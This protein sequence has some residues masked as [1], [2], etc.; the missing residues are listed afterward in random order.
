MRKFYI[1]LLCCSVLLASSQDIHFSQ[2]FNAPLWVNPALTGF[3][4]G[5]ARIGVNYRNQWFSGINNGF[6]KSPFM[7]TA[8]NF[9]MPV[10]VKKD[11][12]GVGV[13]IA[14]DQQGANTFN[15][16]IANVSASYI[17]TLGKERN[18][19]LSAGLQIGGTFYS[20]KTQNL[21]WASQFDANNVY[22]SSLTGE[23]LSRNNAG[24][25][26]LNAGLFWSGVFKQKVGM[27]AGFA[28]NNA[29]VPKYNVIDGQKRSLYFRWNVNAG[30][31][32]IVAKKHHI[33]PSGF[34]TRQGVNDQ[35]NTGIGYG[36]D[37]SERAG[38]T[39]GIYNR[40]H[41]LTKGVTGDAV[42]PYFGF[43][44]SGFKLGLSYDATVSN[45]KNAGTG[46]GALEIYLSY[47]LAK[48]N[49]NFRNAMICPR[50]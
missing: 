47:T 30:L 26:N 3:T 33:L 29:T 5:V 14:S 9:D 22:N 2:T 19:F 50:F 39:L 18:H 37:F 27:Y 31:D 25:V 41:N 17:K 15:G 36:Y 45:F 8:V 12:V 10:Q 20:I 40:I 24:Y 34:F 13:F 32:V 16:V 7:T 21:Q 35:L 23:N 11:A 1:L 6:F 43:N 49:Y 46:V 44:V 4:P 28:V 48:K 42:I 38:I